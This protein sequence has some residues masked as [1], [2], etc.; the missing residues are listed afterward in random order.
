MRRPASASGLNAGERRGNV[1]AM[2]AMRRPF[3][4]ALAAHAVAAVALSVAPTGPPS[5]L[6]PRRALATESTFEVELLP[7]ASGPTPG[8]TAARLATLR[9]PSPLHASGL[10][11][12]RVAE[13]GP[14]ASPIVPPVVPPA[15]SSPDDESWSLGALGPAPASLGAL[16]LGERTGALARQSGIVNE[17]A[18]AEPAPPMRP[19]FEALDRVERE[20]GHGR[21]VPL[22]SAVAEAARG[23]SAPMAGVALFEITV[24]PK[25][26]AQT[27]LVEASSDAA[28]WA[29]LAKTIDSLARAKTVRLPP[30][31]EGLRVVV[32]VEAELRLPDGRPAKDLGV[33]GA[34]STRLALRADAG[35]G[36]SKLVL[37]EATLKFEGKV[38]SLAL[39]LGVGPAPISGGCAPEMIGTRASRQVRAELVSEE[40][41]SQAR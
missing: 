19:L 30:S 35:A 2:N 11:A 6:E 7:P 8:P 13:T 18:G 40:R 37:P 25:T 29:S 15:P 22:R 16:G 3:A 41:I 12:R 21:G 31:G 28:G 27:R 9:A 5:E 39:T 32:R 4:L 23:A 24:G 1:H 26:P 34:V 14:E 10:A 17:T 38:C 36:E 20:A 33:H